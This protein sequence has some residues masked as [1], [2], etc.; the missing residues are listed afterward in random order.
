[1]CAMLLGAIALASALPTNQLSRPH[2]HNHTATH[3]HFTQ[4]FMCASVHIMG[5]LK[6]GKAK[7]M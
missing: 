5:V 1:M 2:A 3:T 6:Y 4:A 7:C